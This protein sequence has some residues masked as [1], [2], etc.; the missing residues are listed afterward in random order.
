[1]T[2][3]SSPTLKVVG[4][5]LLPHLLAIQMRHNLPGKSCSLERCAKRSHKFWPLQVKA[6]G[7]WGKDTLKTGKV[8]FH[9]TGSG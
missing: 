6:Q 7:H 2:P 3:Q 1:M 9:G 8:N 4:A 5:F